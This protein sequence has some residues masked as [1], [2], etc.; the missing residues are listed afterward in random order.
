MARGSRPVASA[1]E[2]R[3]RADCPGLF[4]VRD[5]RGRV[6]SVARHGRSDR[7]SDEASLSAGQCP[8]PRPGGVPRRREA[9]EMNEVEVSGLR[10]GCERE[11]T[12]PPLVLL[13]GGF[14]LDSRSWRRQLDAPSGEYTV[15]AWDAP[16]CGRSF[17]PRAAAVRPASRGTSDPHPGGGTRRVGGLAPDRRARPA[18]VPPSGRHAAARRSGFPATSPGCSPTQ[19]HPRWSRR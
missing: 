19:P 3:R 9:E 2:E 12:G 5:E 1:R 7:V 13:H 4:D 11:G 8:R 17:D 15:V 14:G 16:G 10:I 18:G 6:R